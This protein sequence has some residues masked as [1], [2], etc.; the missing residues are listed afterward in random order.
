M[1]GVGAG[2][3][4]GSISAVLFGRAISASTSSVRLFTGGN[5]YGETVVFPDDPPE[6]A[7]SVYVA[8]RQGFRTIGIDFDAS[9]GDAD[10]DAQDVMAMITRSG[11]RAVLV[12]SGPTGGRH[13]FVTFRERVK[14]AAVTVLHD[15]LA[16]R[17]ASFD[18]S[19]MTPAS[20]IRPPYAPHRLGGTSRV[21]DQEPQAALVALREGNDPRLLAEV[22]TACGVPAWV[23]GNAVADAD[24]K[25]AVNRLTPNVREL[26]ITGKKRHGDQ[27][28]SGVV[29][30]ILLGA[31]NAGL[32]FAT[33]VALLREPKHR[34]GER[35]RNN[36]TRHGEKRALEFF[37]REWEHATR[38]ADEHPTVASPTDVRI[39]LAEQLDLAMQLE[40]KGI[41]GNTDRAVYIALVNI[42]IRNGTLTPTASHRQL[43]EL[44]KI[45][46]HGTIGRSLRRLAKRGLLCKEKK[47]R[48]KQ[49]ST[50]SVSTALHSEERATNHLNLGGCE[51]S[52]ALLGTTL[53]T[54]QHDVFRRLGLG[55]SGWQIYAALDLVD[56]ST[57]KQIAG[58]SKKHRSTVYA[59][60]PRLRDVGLAVDV[61]PGRWIKLDANLDEVAVALDVQDATT[62]QHARHE[63]EREL[64]R[65]ARVS[66][67]RTE[68]GMTWYSHR[69]RKTSNG[70]PAVSTVRPATEDSI[71]LAHIF[72]VTFD[73]PDVDEH[74]MKW[75][76][77]R[78][79][80]D[81]GEDRDD[82]FATFL[83][84]MQRHGDGAGSDP[85]DIAR[86][87]IAEE[88]RISDLENPEIID[89]IL[90]GNRQVTDEPSNP[91][92]RPE[93]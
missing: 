30:S 6:V 25:S 79:G 32:D 23:A 58:L 17:Y 81:R 42:A 46:G 88:I 68:N 31:I 21:L 33:T 80:R 19:C 20:T 36:I 47:G 84:A 62:R 89:L 26:L 93:N 27:T 39:I 11:L 87:I 14:P 60:L 3:D 76:P 73:A 92:A 5:N 50:F 69:R 45:E 56:S 35:H 70:P 61:E 4:D 55:L 82:L 91:H 7:W 53:I 48:G 8:D 38:Y 63:F 40:W 1:A 71:R 51:I 29:W 37:W 74:G 90:A 24:I 75:F 41:A 16:R 54:T 67:T 2:S 66:V 65:D 77:S 85:S 59:F 57:P 86:V 22:L 72:N 12:E 18:P 9:K 83:L 44:A 15:Q 34:A 64:Y 43:A 28:R 78:R 10:G 49:A 13:V 52:G